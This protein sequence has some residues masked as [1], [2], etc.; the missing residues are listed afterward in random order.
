[1]RITGASIHRSI[2]VLP[3][4]YFFTQVVQSRAATLHG[5]AADQSDCEK[6]Q[7]QPRGHHNLMVVLAGSR[8]PGVYRPPVSSGVAGAHLER[9]A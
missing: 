1:M 4:P 7:G 9:H 6:G 5:R 8:P 2:F 3:P